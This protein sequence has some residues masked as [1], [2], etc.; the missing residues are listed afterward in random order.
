MESSLSRPFTEVWKRNNP[1][2]SFAGSGMDFRTGI[3]GSGELGKE[4]QPCTNSKYRN[5]GT[6]K[7]ILF[8]I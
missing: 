1:P 4:R 6:I 3:G 8:K 2:A 7:F 5:V